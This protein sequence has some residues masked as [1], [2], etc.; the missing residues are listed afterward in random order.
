MHSVSTGMS[1]VACGKDVTEGNLSDVAQQYLR[2]LRLSARRYRPV[3]QV[4]V[5]PE[6]DDESAAAPAV[7]TLL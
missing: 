2:L 6:F 4:V 7:N 3:R 5:Q 1:G